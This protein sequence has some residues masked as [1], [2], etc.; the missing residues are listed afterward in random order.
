MEHSPLLQQVAQIYT[1]TIFDLFQKE[2]D[3]YFATYIEKG[4]EGEPNHEYLISV[5]NE[6]GE[7][8]VSFNPSIGTISCSCRKFETFG[9][10]CCHAIK[11]LNQYIRKRWTRNAKNGCVKD[12]YGRNVQ[13]DANLDS[14][15]W[16]REV[17][18]KLVKIA[19]CASNCREVYSFV[20]KAIEELSKQVYNI[21]REN[22]GLVNNVNPSSFILNTNHIFLQ[23]KGLKR[24][25]NIVKNY[26][27][28][29][30]LG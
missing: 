12:S 24:K 28:S 8:K 11:I 21:C 4:N 14:T 2:Y 9:I 16:Y 10:L 19:T 18:P 7:F 15:Q 1:L 26:K 30:E 20:E 3:K 25:K 13:E 23:A 22:L 17:C 6:N 5:C 29:K 27:M